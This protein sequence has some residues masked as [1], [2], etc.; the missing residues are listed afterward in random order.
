MTLLTLAGI[1]IACFACGA[2]VAMLGLRRRADALAGPPSDDAVAAD[3]LPLTASADEMA[4]ALEALV[5]SRTEMRLVGIYAGREGAGALDAR[6]RAPG[7][8]ARLPLH[9]PETL[10][11]QVRR[12]ELVDADELARG[13]RPG[14]PPAAPDVEASQ[15]AAERVAEEKRAAESLNE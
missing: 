1:S 15:L 6:W 10:L 8:E 13:M 12:P 4:R 9:A 14:L 5:G 7:A 3:A 11:V 2:A